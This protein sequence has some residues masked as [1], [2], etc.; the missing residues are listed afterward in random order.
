MSIKLFFFHIKYDRS[1]NVTLYLSER[2][3]F[4][5]FNLSNF[6]SSHYEHLDRIELVWEQ[7]KIELWIRKQVYQK[8]QCRPFPRSA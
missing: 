6:C 7:Q 8:H 2:N 4:S 5:L 3:S 1:E